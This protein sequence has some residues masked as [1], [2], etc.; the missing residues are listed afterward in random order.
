MFFRARQQVGINV[1][2]A[3]MQA[4]FSEDISSWDPTLIF[5]DPADKLN[6]IR[7]IK[8]LLSYGTDIKKEKIYIKVVNCCIVKGKVIAWVTL[9]ERFN[10]LMYKEVA[11][12]RKRG[13]QIF[14]SIPFD[15]QQRK[16]IFLNI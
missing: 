8:D 1:T 11:A 16:K 6:R 13:F 15:A 3:Q 7:A 9:N 2:I 10:N 4:G 12:K 5:I 14:S